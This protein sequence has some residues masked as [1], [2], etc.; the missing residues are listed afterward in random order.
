MYQLDSVIVGTVDTSGLYTRSYALAADYRNIQFMSDAYSQGINQLVYR[1]NTDSIIIEYHTESCSNSPNTELLN[2]VTIDSGRYTSSYHAVKIGCYGQD[3]MQE[4]LQ[5]ALYHTDGRLNA[6]NNQYNY[7]VGSDNYQEATVN[8]SFNYSGTLLNSLVLQ[9]KEYHNYR[10]DSVMYTV[11]N[12]VNNVHHYPNQTDK[13][14]IDVND[15]IINYLFQYSYPASGNTIYF[16]TLQFPLLISKRV[17]YHTG[18]DYLIEQVHFPQIPSVTFIPFY[19][20]IPFN[21]N[22]LFIN[23]TFDAAHSDRIST[24]TLRYSPLGFFAPNDAVRYTFVYKN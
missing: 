12:T 16:A 11:T 9:G 23:Y 24:M 2:Y 14:G 20:N 10:A 8:T 6:L 4:Y 5:S 22:D 17:S 1:T 7:I 15:L 19:T 3:G 21:D 18:S 13:I